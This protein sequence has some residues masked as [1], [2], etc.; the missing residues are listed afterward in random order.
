MNKKFFEENLNLFIE[1]STNTKGVV[2]DVYVSI[3]DYN[4]QWN[5]FIFY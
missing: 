3:G 5:I 2:F 1:A 4:S